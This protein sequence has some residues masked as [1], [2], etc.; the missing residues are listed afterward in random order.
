MDFN[1]V[2]LNDINLD[3]DNFDEDY[4]ETLNHARPMTWRNT[5]KQRNG[6]KKEIRKK[7]MSVAWHRIR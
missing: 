1:S 3:D 7:L 5:F 2:D 4:P 6:Y